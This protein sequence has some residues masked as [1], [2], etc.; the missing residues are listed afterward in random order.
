MAVFVER[1]LQKNKMKNKPIIYVMVIVKVSILNTLSVC[2]H[3]PVIA[4]SGYQGNRKTKVDAVSPTLYCKITL[5]EDNNTS[6][7][8]ST[9][10]TNDCM[11]KC[12]SIV[13]AQVL[14][15]I[16]VPCCGIN[17]YLAVPSATVRYP[18]AP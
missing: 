1:C 18:L 4:S 17:N 15:Y 16:A 2:R 12:V 11:L 3:A 8:I 10:C 9:A 7:R 14:C 5:Q 6:E 13:S